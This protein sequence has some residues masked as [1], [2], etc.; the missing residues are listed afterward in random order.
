[1][2]PTLPRRCA[3]FVLPVR[4]AAVV[5]TA[6]LLVGCASTPANPDDPLEGFNRAMF[7]FN[8]GVDTAVLR[9]AA[10]AYETVTPGL[11]RTG[12]GNVFGNLGDVWIGANNL[13][14]GKVGDGMSDLMRFMVNSTIGLL[15]LLDVASEMGLQKNDED[16][17]QTLAVWGVGEGPYLVLPIFGPRTLRDAAAIP[18]DRF[19]DPV[20]NIDHSRTRYTATG[21]R[22]VHGRARLLS[23]ERTF[24]DSTLD[25]YTFMRD[26]YLQQRRYKVHDGEVPFEYDDYDFFDDGFDEQAS[27]LPARTGVEVLVDSALAQLELNR[28]E[29]AAPGRTASNIYFT[30]GNER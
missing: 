22:V 23:V 27:L 20:A 10:R 21:L 15:G 3:R 11:V 7:A 29:G 28:A 24:E 19:G 26:S 8:E 25:K 2:N 14:Q 17:G 1:M 9:P 13:L 12:V 16:F 30:M 6:M 4:R 5:L 18:V